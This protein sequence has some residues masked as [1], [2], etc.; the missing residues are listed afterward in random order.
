[1]KRIIFYD[2]ACSFCHRGVAFIVKRDKSQVFSFAS[3]QSDVAKDLLMHA[4]VPHDVD[5]IVL[6]EGNRT[7]IKSTAVF[8][9]CRHLRGL[10]KLGVVFLVLPK[11]FRDLCYDI[12]AKNRYKWFG[13]S[14]RCALP[15]KEARKRFLS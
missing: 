1:M 9:I 4:Q 8:K 6:L 12:V 3:L 5:S 7:Y 15:P 2:G 14:K 10:W 11:V 13:K